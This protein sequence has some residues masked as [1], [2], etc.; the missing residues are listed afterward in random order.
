[1]KKRY[2]RVYKVN[3]F[4]P[5]NSLF[6]GINNGY[7]VNEWKFDVVYNHLTFIQCKF[8]WC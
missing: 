8:S 6:V 4:I 1:M 5:T 3:L 7:S 2:W